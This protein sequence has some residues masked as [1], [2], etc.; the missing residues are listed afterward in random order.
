MAI[1]NQV[2]PSPGSGNIGAPIAGAV[3]PP[4]NPDTLKAPLTATQRKAILAYL[5]KVEGGNW[6]GYNDTQLIADYKWAVAGGR[7]SGILGALGNAPGA[8]A[9]AVAPSWADALANVLNAL[10]SAA[11]WIRAAEVVGGLI[12]IT[13]G[14]NHLAIKALQPVMAN[15]VVKQAIKVA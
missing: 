13:V 5:H 11:F 4:Y 14:L 8:V 3:A 1:L 9:G 10:G 2:P 12:L 15:P 7:G 6:S